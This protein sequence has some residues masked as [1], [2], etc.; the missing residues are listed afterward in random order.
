MMAAQL[1]PGL[2]LDCLGPGNILAFPR[3]ETQMPEI[4]YNKGSSGLSPVPRSPR[5]ESTN[6]LLVPCL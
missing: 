2:D 6:Q 4:Y 5:T 3:Q 1:G